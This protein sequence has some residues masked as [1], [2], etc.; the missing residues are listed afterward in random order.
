MY[1]I[2]EKKILCPQVKEIVLDV[3]AIAQKAQAGQF[4]VIRIDEK[5]ER[6][7]LTVAD[8]DREKGTMTVIFQEAGKT[9]QQLGALNKGDFIMDVAGPMGISSSMEKVGTVVCVGGGVGSAALYILLKAFKKAGNKTVAIT[10]AK[11]KEFLFWEEKIKSVSSEMFITTDDGSY[12][13]KGFVTE[14]LEAFIKKEKCDLIFAV[15]PVVMMNAVCRVSEPHKI[16]TIVSLNSIMVDA[17]GMCGACRVEVGGE[18]KF[19]CVDGPDFDGHKVNFDLLLLR[20]KMY[21]T[22]EKTILKERE[23][24]E[25]K[26]CCCNNE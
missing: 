24:N 8:Y 4:I 13:R 11:S 1:K 23:K 21:L 22:E 2:L 19:A 25:G 26:S 16:K 3:P 12:G 6:I 20:Q 18:T 14:E 10:G 17:T 9:T 15:G 5:G 7:P